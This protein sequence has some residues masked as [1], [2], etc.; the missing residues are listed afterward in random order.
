MAE[1]DPLVEAVGLTRE[2]GV[3]SPQPF[4]AVYPASFKFYVGE[5]IVIT[6]KSGSGKSTLLNLLGLLDSPTGGTYRLAGTHVIGAEESRL[7]EMRRG[8]IGF[9]FQ[10][11]YL[12]GWKTALENTMD[13]LRGRAKRPLR[14]E[15][16]LRALSAVGLIDRLN[17]YPNTLSGGERQRVALARALVKEPP[18]LLCDEPTGSLDTAMG[19]S[20]ADQLIALSQSGTTTVVVTH[21]ESIADRLGGRRLSIAD[22]VLTGDGVG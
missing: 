2:F 11:S 14:Q 19:A 15:A 10:A 1:A 4:V 12:V 20:V 22:G 9:V 8:M 3:N 18:L 6:G 7:S 21:D 5:M 17:S 16:A 13:G